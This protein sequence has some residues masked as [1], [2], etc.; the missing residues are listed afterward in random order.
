MT[1]LKLPTEFALEC[2][3][4]SDAALRQHV[5]GLLAVMGRE[6][7]GALTYTEVRRFSEGANFEA[8]CK[9]LVEKK[10]WTETA[11]GYD[12][13]HGMKH[14]PEPDLIRQRRELSQELVRK[15]RRARAGLPAEP[16][17]NDVT[18]GVTERATERVTRD[19]DLDR[20]QGR[21]LAAVEPREDQAVCGYHGGPLPCQVT[22]C[23]FE[24][25]EGQAKLSAVSA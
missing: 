23:E 14:Q 5:E 6:T 20:G 11:T 15:Y 17:S 18:E 7:G 16:A 2:A 3:G 25:R 19:R 13:V 24:L 9:E 12:V 1:W 22:R 10:F 8:A 4:L 21:D